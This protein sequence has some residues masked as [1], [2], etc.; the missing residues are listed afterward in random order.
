MQNTAIALAARMT[1]TIQAKISRPDMLL[2]L[3]RLLRH[4]RRRPRATKNL[5][6]GPVGTDITQQISGG[7]GQPIGAMDRISLP[8]RLHVDGKRAVGVWFEILVLG[9]DRDQVD[10]V[11]YK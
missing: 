11:G 5:R 1:R 10:R 9:A 4:R 2:T 7:R 3:L 8:L 6:H